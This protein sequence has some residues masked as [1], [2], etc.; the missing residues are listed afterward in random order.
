M[1][2]QVQNAALNDQPTDSD[3]LAE[4]HRH[5]QEEKR[6]NKRLQQASRHCPRSRRLTSTT[7][8]PE[9]VSD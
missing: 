6:L 1:N 4:A 7:N 5:D 3:K 9:K 8:S 2:T